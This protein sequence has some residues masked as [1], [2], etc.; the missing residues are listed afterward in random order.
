MSVIFCAEIIEQI[1]SFS[2]LR[3]KNDAEGEF[4]MGRKIKEDPFALVK[5]K[6]H[7]QFKKLQGNYLK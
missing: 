3:H 1:D 4:D 5:E 7:E 2:Q 6:E